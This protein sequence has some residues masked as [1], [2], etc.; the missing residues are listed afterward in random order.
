[1]RKILLTFVLGLLW[2]NVVFSENYKA[3]QEV[4]GQIVF[5]KKIKIDLPEGKWTLVSR[6]L[7]NWHGLNLTDYTLIKIK[8]NEISEGISVG[9]FKLGGIAIGQIDPI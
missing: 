1:M 2:C 3:G 7:W 8:D 4:E 5:S 9:E 6:S